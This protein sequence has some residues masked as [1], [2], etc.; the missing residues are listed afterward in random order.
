MSSP[1]NPEHFPRGIALFLDIDGTLLEIAE[2]PESV[3]VPQKLKRLISELRSC[4]EGAVAFISGRSIANIDKLFE[5]LKLPTSGKHGLERRDALGQRHGS[6]YLALQEIKS[7]RKELGKFVLQ[8][9]GTILEDKGETVALHYRLRPKAKEQAHKI[10]RSLLLHHKKL[11]IIAG[12]MVFEVRPKS[13]NKGIAIASFLEEPPFF[14]KT[15]I[16]IGDDRS[17][18]DGFKMVNERGGLSI[19]VSHKSPSEARWRLD[20]VSEVKIWL[21]AFVAN[22]KKNHDVHH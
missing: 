7:F 17:D 21:A 15:P 1:L 18:E 5:P 12:K 11:E 19:L 8:N 16:F 6:E 9:P 20:D 22:M 2:K 4:L 10:I 14:G 13:S 3:V